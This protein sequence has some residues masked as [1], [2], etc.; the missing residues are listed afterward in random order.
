MPVSDLHG[1]DGRVAAGGIGFSCQYQ[2][3]RAFLLIGRERRCRAWPG[4]GMIHPRT[5]HVPYLVVLSPAPSQGQR[6]DLTVGDLVVGRAPTSDIRFAEPDVS[7]RHAALRRQGGAVFIEDLG[8]SGGTFV[9]EEQVTARRALQD[10]DVVAF[11]SS[12]RLRY[13]AGEAVGGETQVS[14]GPL[15]GSAPPSSAVRAPTVRY[16]IG[17]QAAGTI[18]NVGHNQYNS[19][20]AHVSQQ[21]ENFLREIAATRTKARWLV[22]SGFLLF[23]VGFGLFA[24][25]VLGFIGDVSDAVESGNV[26]PPDD[27]F[28]QDIGG[29]PSGLLGWAIAAIGALLVVVGIVLHIVATSRRRRVDRELAVPPPWQGAGQWEG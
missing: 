4:A 2:A 29:V 13:G 17:S 22:W 16:D 20:V 21:R 23:V 3:G 15:V 24:A 10:G 28:G 26:G 14:D 19:Y 27:P 5:G 18:S 8:S 7:R 25:G 6:F 12:V 11:A 9:N 1:S